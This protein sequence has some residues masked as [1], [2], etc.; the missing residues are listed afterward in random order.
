MTRGRFVVMTLMLCIALFAGVIVGSLVPPFGP[1][2]A[3]DLKLAASPA[4]ATTVVV[5]SFAELAER[6]IPSIVHIRKTQLVS[7][8]SE[9]DSIPSPLRRFFEQ[10]PN[11]E[12]HRRPD[13]GGNGA[14]RRERQGSAGSGFFIT[15]DGYIMTN[16]HVV[17]GADELEVQTN[18]QQRHP[19]KL[20]GIDPHLDLAIVKIE[21]DKPTP[22]LPLGDSDT[23]RVGEWA[24]AIGNPLFF[25]NS[26]TVGVISGKERTQVGGRN[27]IG[28][29]I[30][31]DAAINFGNSGGPLL[32]VRGEVIGINT[33]I[34]R[35][36]GQP[37]PFSGAQDSTLEG[38]GFALPI[39]QAKRSLDQLI[40]T[41]TV[42]RGYMGA[43]VEPVTP[44]AAES[45]RFPGG[46]SGAL[47]GGVTKQ[48]PADAA[49]L[50]Q[51][52]IIMAVDGRQIRSSNELVNVVS[53]YKPGDKIK[54]TLWRDGAE[55]SVSV[56]LTERPGEIASSVPTEQQDKTEPDDNGEVEALGLTVAPLPPNLRERLSDLGFKGGVLIKD[57][58][59]TSDAAREGLSA[60]YIVL[61]VNG[62]PTLTVAD[63][64]KAAGSAKP[65]QVVRLRTLSPRGDD[66]LVFF[67]L[68]K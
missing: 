31:T 21:V 19:A 35:G 62:T 53:G 23:L 1:A 20:I 44:E 49:G 30:Q 57:V 59:E 46:I 60:P 52:D 7:S 15:S 32:N 10:M 36:N 65:G 51:G 55:K 40:K 37:N 58:D 38:L 2:S 45:F 47:V 5:P 54:L 33:A 27:D 56:T 12:N 18:D 66:R 22:A 3:Q 41:G 24:V 42:K 9:S 63:F 28:G 39:S 11:D 48:T 4:S 6:A 29:Y 13:D 8:D 17:D 64:R 43:Q 67:R 16:R 25:E 61:E 50:E 14:P 68:S 34:I 26:V